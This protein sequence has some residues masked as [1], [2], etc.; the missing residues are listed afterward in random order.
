MDP[1]PA[2]QLPVII[3]MVARERGITGVHTHV[4]Q[5]RTYLHGVGEAAEVVTPHTWAG[6]GGRWRAPALVP[7]FGARVILERTYG[8]ANVWWYR[9]SHEHV[10]RA[11]LRT[12]LAHAATVCGLRAVPGV[13]TGGP[14][15]PDGPAP[16]G[17]ARG[18]LPHLAGR[19]VGG[20]GPD[21]PGRA[22]VRVDPGHRALR[23][24]TGRRARVRVGLGARGAARVAAGGRLRA[25]RRGP[26]LRQPHHGTAPHA[27]TRATS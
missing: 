8:P 18:A 10:L 21:R 16:A 23:G 27:R 15:R 24:A 25:A 2:A 1:D 20:Q 3:A 7:P 17:R 19:R 12:A 11:A 5:L 6:P 22:G 13:G 4:R 26:Q 14:G 9:T